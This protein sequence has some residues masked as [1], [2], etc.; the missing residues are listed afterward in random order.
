MPQINL[1]FSV[2]TIHRVASNLIDAPSTAIRWGTPRLHT[3]NPKTRMVK[4]THNP[5][6]RS[7]I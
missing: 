7:L 5:L 4:I 3:Q 1:K 6:Y 2:S